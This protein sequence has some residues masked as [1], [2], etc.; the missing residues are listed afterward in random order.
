MSTPPLE[1]AMRLAV[2]ASWMDVAAYTA[3]K[4][5]VDAKLAREGASWA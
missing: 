2:I 1:I 4:A 3:L 5:A